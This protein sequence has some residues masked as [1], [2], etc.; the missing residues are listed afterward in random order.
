[1]KA[2]TV[3]LAAIFGQAIHA[4]VNEGTSPADLSLAPCVRGDV[5]V[6]DLQAG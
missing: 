5:H 1:M 6:A 3:D 4:L 2:D